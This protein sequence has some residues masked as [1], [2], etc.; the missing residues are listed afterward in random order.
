M[1]AERVDKFHKYNHD[2]YGKLVV[3]HYM[4]DARDEVGHITDET[5]EAIG[6][7]YLAKAKQYIEAKQYKVIRVLLEFPVYVVEIE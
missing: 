7:E 5:L 6:N 1:K 2:F 3:V 4:N